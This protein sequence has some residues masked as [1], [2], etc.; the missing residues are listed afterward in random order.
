MT[1]EEMIERLVTH[2]HLSCWDCDTYHRLLER[3][4]DRGLKRWYIIEFG[5]WSLEMEHRLRAGEVEA[6]FEELIGEE[7]TLQLPPVA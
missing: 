7:A 4:D 6:L 3:Q 1:R 2:N 5:E